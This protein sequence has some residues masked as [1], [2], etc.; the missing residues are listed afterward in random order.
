MVGAM[1]QGE[2]GAPQWG[3]FMLPPGDYSVRDTWFTAGMCG[4][5]SK[6]IVTD[7]AFVPETR[8]L[9]LPDLRLGKGPG[10]AL[11]ASPIYRMPFF[12]YAPLCFAAPMLGAAQGAYGHFRDWTKIRKAVDGSAVAEKISVQ[13][14]MARAAADL[15]AAELLL[16]R[17]A[18]VRDVPPVAAVPA[19]LA[20]SIRDFARVSEMSV[21]AVDAL[22]LLSGAA[23][24]ASSEPM[25]RTWRDLHF[26]ASHIGV[27]T[28]INYSHF[29]R[30]ELGLP[31]D[32]NRPFF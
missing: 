22:M 13:V 29:G 5:G 4:T 31:R 27:N 11:H 23:G 17:V 20:R 6:T 16:R 26:A 25:Q 24:F 10:G 32:P 7:D 1:A 28:E 12:F 21:A 15:D 19:L 30:T 9:W 3:L 8:V 14:G 18:Q 2:G